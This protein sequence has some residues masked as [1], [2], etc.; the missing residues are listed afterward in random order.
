MATVVHGNS[1]GPELGFLMS[2]ID[3]LQTRGL[4]NAYNK[5][6]MNLLSGVEKK[7][8]A[9]VQEPDISVTQ[10]GQVIVRDDQE[11]EVFN[12]KNNVTDIIPGEKRDL[13]DDELYDL[14]M[15][16]SMKGKTIGTAYPREMREDVYGDYL[17]N[18]LK[19]M[20]ASRPRGGSGTIKNFVKIDTETGLPQKDIKGN[21]TIKSGQSAPP[22]GSNEKNTGWAYLPSNVTS[23]MGTAIKN[24]QGEWTLDLLDIQKPDPSTNKKKILT[25][26][27]AGQYYNKTNPKLPRDKRIKQA[28]AMAIKDG[29]K[30][31]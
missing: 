23:Q 4:H 22:I 28:Q 21:Y 10:P 11:K 27:I 2:M 16:A 24:A 17:N 3:N 7:K 9:G 31:K 19:K 12:Q 20:Q 5:E 14:Y 15:N 26:E 29:Y 18:E 6:M 13:N 30:E 8:E 25:E 1:F